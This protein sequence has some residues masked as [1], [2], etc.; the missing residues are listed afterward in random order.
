MQYSVC[1]TGRASWDLR[2]DLLLSLSVTGWAASCWRTDG[3]YHLDWEV[4]LWR[5]LPQNRFL[6]KLIHLDF[7]IRN[8]SS[9]WFTC[10]SMYPST[11]SS[12][13]LHIHLSSFHLICCFCCFLSTILDQRSISSQR[14]VSHWGNRWLLYSSQFPNTSSGWKVFSA[15]CLTLLRHK[16][17]HSHPEGI[18]QHYSDLLLLF[19]LPHSVSFL[20]LS[21]FCPGSFQLPVVWFFIW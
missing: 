14:N 5:T 3:K 2:G 8:P 15:L 19:P 10:P 18:C 9:F 1:L 20:L 12:T 17:N 4:P 11:Y 13:Y 21:L 16:F 6:S 7:H